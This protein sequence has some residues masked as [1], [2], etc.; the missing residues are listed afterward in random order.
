MRV[1]LLPLMLLTISTSFAAT[2][3][4]LRTH[5]KNT[6]NYYYVGIS[7]GQSKLQAAMAEAYNNALVEAV[8][9]NFGF[10]QKFVEAF[11][12]S[13]N[14]S[15]HQQE[16]IHT[17]EDIHLD[18]IEP[19]RLKVIK[20]DKGYLVYR[21][22]SY[23]IKAI[24]KEQVRLKN[25]QLKSQKTGK[26]KL[27]GKNLG[28]LSLTTK[29]TLA[30]VILT[31]EDGKHQVMGTSNADFQVPVGKYQLVV[32]LN[33]YETINKNILITGKSQSHHIILKPVLGELRFQVT[34]EDAIITVDG[35]AIKTNKI[36]LKSNSE[37]KIQINHP[38]YYQ[39]SE[40]TYLMP[41]EKKL[42]ALTLNPRPSYVTILSEPRG[43]DVYLNDEFW[44][45]TPIK[46]KQISAGSYNLRI[47]KNKF[48]EVQKELIVAANRK[49]SPEI[50]QLKFKGNDTQVESDLD[51]EVAPEYGTS[52]FTLTYMP[53]HD[54]RYGQR[55][56]LLPMGFEYTGAYRLRYGFEFMMYQKEEEMRTNEYGIKSTHKFMTS[57]MIYSFTTRI[58]IWRSRYF[59]IGIGPGFHHQVFRRR[60]ESSGSRYGAAKARSAQYRR[61]DSSLGVGLALEIG[62][63]IRH[64][65]GRHKN[66][67]SV[68]M[69]FEYRR[70][71]YEEEF[72]RF[73]AGIYWHF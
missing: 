20:Q 69:R 56:Y 41:R 15:E 18:Q 13:L 3:W 68:G 21:E 67:G 64:R 59:R 8:K 22:I 47:K 17:Q 71:N 58:L 2:K 30:E 19:T 26:Y 42:F 44:G 6:T 62:K 52:Y 29:P 49:S 7:E 14:Q 31:D 32:S 10:N 73:A 54:D 50:Y 57:Y 70:L 9:H 39:K 1:L 33:G 37:H 23:P 43:A 51:L 63:E 12:S 24:K 11:H 66:G 40:I 4:W 45:K 36:R 48:Y 5:T 27:G 38:D 35:R 72:N 46:G 53:Y 55:F 65:R 16:M 61:T 25:I 28:T 34:P 60:L